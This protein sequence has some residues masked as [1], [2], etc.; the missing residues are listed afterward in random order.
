MGPGDGA[1]P[2][3]HPASPLARPGR[4]RPAPQ[5]ELTKLQERLNKLL[6][7][8][9]L[10]GGDMSPPGGQSGL[11]GWR[12]LFDLVE[13]AEAFILFAELPGVRHSDVQLD[14]DGNWLELSG[15]RRP[16]G[17]ERGYLRLEGNYGA[18]KRRLELP[19]PVD[20]DG[21]VA[22]LQRGILEVMMPKLGSGRRGGQ[23]AEVPVREE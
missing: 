13:T 11:S 12:P 5:S 22:R 23:R 18:F 14:S 3:D 20:P 21:I 8:A 6:E 17:G 16:V 19:E 1:W 2:H 9:L 7:Q 10:G 15:Q 4:P